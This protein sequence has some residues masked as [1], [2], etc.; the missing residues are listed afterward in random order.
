MNPVDRDSIL[1]DLIKIIF[2]EYA[3]EAER[4]QSEMD[5]GIFERGKLD[6]EIKNVLKCN[7]VLEKLFECV[8]DRSS[9]PKEIIEAVKEIR[10]AKEKIF[11]YATTI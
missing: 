10:P 3:E 11:S 7:D 1:I 4:I 5:A 8:D 2:I 9:I 6:L